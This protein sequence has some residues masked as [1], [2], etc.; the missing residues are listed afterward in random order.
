MLTGGTRP[1]RRVGAK[2]QT[3]R[4]QSGSHLNHAVAR[5]PRRIESSVEIRGR[6]AVGLDFHT[7]EN[8]HLEIAVTGVARFDR[9]GG[10]APRAAG[11]L[12]VA[13]ACAERTK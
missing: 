11:R 12:L 8:Q 1:S 3:C 4:V 5:S 9:R 13:A 7:R 6:V 10:A 2:A